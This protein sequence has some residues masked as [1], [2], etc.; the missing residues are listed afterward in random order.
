MSEA[1]NVTDISIVIDEQFRGPPFSGNGGYV[2]GRL[3]RLLGA[4]ESVEVTLRSPIPM[5]RELDIE[6]RGPD[7]VVVTDGETL[8]AEATKSPLELDVPA[9]PSWEETLAAKQDSF[10]FVNWH[11]PMQTDV[12]GVHPICFCCGAD[13]ES[14]L[15]VFAAPV[16]EGA[17]VAAIWKTKK[18]WAEDGNQ[19]PDEFL[20]AA[21]DCPGQFAYMAGGV[22]TGML[23]R[24]TGKVH[25]S[26]QAGDEYLVTGWRINVEGKKHA[27][28]TAIFT[29]NGE[30][31]A[32]ARALWIGQREM[33]E[34]LK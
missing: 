7:S 13:H 2:A 3:A 33:P 6:Y 1:V 22:F 21:L 20:W 19:L 25:Q 9:P 23:G 16:Q 28:G 18:E 15:D 11:N 27:A 30:L 10:S 8:V 17:Q 34:F 14:G 24:L 29:R 4:G 5:D 31:I 26:A 12:R 32:S